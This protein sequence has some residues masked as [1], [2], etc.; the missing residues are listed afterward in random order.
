MSATARVT[1]HA[2]NTI[3]RWLERASPAAKRVTQRMLPD[4]LRARSPARHGSEVV[5]GYEILNRMTALG[6]PVC[7]RRRPLGSAGVGLAV[8]QSA[9][10]QA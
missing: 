6:R 2:R 4:G 3:A 7:H 10:L 5:L 1:G 8:L 9:N